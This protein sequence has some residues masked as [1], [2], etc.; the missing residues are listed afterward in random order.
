MKKAFVFIF[1]IFMITMSLSAQEE[2]GLYFPPGQQYVYLGDGWSEPFR[3][4]NDYYSEGWGTSK[5][6]ME[7]LWFCDRGEIITGEDQLE[8]LL[9][10]N[11]GITGINQT[12]YTNSTYEGEEYEE[13]VITFSFEG[14]HYMAWA[15]FRGDFFPTMVLIF[16]PEEKWS[17]IE[18]TMMNLIMKF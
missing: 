1:V 9:N 14:S 15:G 2:D 18:D 17:S 3:I 10:D 13:L 4:D 6:D 8:R 12:G 16:V 5:D 7:V 11:P